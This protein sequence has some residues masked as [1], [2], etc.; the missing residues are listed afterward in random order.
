MTMLR[1]LNEQGIVRLIEFLHAV[2][3]DSSLALA[4]TD[5]L[6]NPHKVGN[7][8]RLKYSNVPS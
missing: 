8:T 4:S 6:D 5:L 7:P 2:K 3:S 1:R